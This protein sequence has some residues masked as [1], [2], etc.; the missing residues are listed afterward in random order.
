MQVEFNAGTNT[1]I[2][3]EPDDSVVIS[4]PFTVIGNLSYT[5]LLEQ[6]AQYDGFPIALAA[7]G[8]EEVLRTVEV[9][10]DAVTQ[11]GSQN[12]IYESTVGSITPIENKIYRVANGDG[13]GKARTFHYDGSTLNQLHETSIPVI[14]LPKLNQTNAN[15]NGGNN[16]TWGSPSVNTI[17]GSS[18]TETE[19][20]LPEGVYE[21]TCT[22]CYTANVTRVSVLSRFAV[23][24]ILEGPIGAGGYIRN[25]SGH[26]ESSVTI[27][28]VIVISSG[29]A[30]V[31]LNLRRGAAA[32]TV[33]ATTNSVL[34]VKK[35]S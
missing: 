8:G 14:V 17:S 4:S 9:I 10:E 35:L 6:Y 28:H 32:G 1:V 19:V 24:G 25:T 11:A 12:F 23:G 5:D 20:V 3:I 18:V 15:S 26:N 2:Q 31:T 21:L 16:A 30:T 13:F 22:M 7:I 27:N 34:V 33:T 29:T